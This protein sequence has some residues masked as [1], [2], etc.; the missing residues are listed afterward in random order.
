MT[1]QMLPLPDPEMSKADQIRAQAA[2]TISNAGVGCSHVRSCSRFPPMR[3]ASFRK[4][5]RGEGCQSYPVLTIISLANG[6]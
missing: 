2:V 1:G 4:L 5:E 6:E 3:S